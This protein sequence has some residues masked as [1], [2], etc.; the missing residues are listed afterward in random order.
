RSFEDSVLGEAVFAR[1]VLGRL[2]YAHRFHGRTRGIANRMRWNVNLRKIKSE[3]AAV[4]GN[5]DQPDFASKQARQL[6][7][8]R[9]TQPGAAVFAAGAAI[10]L[11][12][13]LED[14]LLFFLR[15]ADTGVGNREG[16]HR[17]SAIQYFVLRIPS[18][19]RPLHIQN[20]VTAM[21][22]FER[23]RQE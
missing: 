10:G 21:R 1:F 16:Q 12:E 9:Q 11:L 14:N 3:G 7:A 20:D 8:N 19:F 22:K 17:R 6:T 2:G 15:Y 5:T 23:I 4:A 18:A 13:S